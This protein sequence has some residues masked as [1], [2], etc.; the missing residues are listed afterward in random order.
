MGAV[1]KE[2]WKMF[3]EN[4]D[5]SRKPLLHPV[6]I[7]AIWPCPG[8]R[9]PIRGYFN[10]KKLKQYWFG[11]LN[12]YHSYQCPDRPSLLSGHVLTFLLPPTRNPAHW[13]IHMTVLI[14]FAWSRVWEEANSYKMKKSRHGNRKWFVDSPE[15]H[16][17]I[18]YRIPHRPLKQWSGVVGHKRNQRQRCSR[19]ISR[20]TSSEFQWY[21]QPDD[22]ERGDGS[23]ESRIAPGASIDTHMV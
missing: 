10:W 14:K 12:I 8:G 22:G 4:W 11:N 6:T 13:T 19:P 3:N 17:V 20:P 1:R 7:T 15:V 21:R 18:H 23:G 2:N 16:P 9:M 5:F